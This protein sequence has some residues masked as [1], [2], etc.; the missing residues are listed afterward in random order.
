[1]HFAKS[2]YYFKERGFEWIELILREN[3]GV[4]ARMDLIYTNITATSGK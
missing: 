1:M 3:F 2:H 4:I